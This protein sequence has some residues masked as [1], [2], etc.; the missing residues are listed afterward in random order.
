[1]VLATVIWAIRGVGINGAVFSGAAS[2]LGAFA[3]GVVPHSMEAVSAL[4]WERLLQSLLQTLQMAVCGTVLGI[5]VSLPLGIM[6]AQP[7]MAPSWLRLPV[8]L[9]LN[10]IRTLPSLIWALI[11]V[12]MVGLGP[13]SGVL[14]LSAYSMGYLT[15]FFYED[16]E[17]IDTRPAMAVRALGATRLQT[18]FLAILP[19][20]MPMLLGS[21]FF[22]FEYN[23][24]AASVLGV[25]GAGGIGQDLMYYIEWRQF[26]NHYGI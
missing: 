22:M 17:S 25:V 19:A 6:A 3:R 2:A 14:A 18:F 5:I 8:R 16:L 11:F 12:A 24:R 9:L 10:A 26:I 1:L 7:I 4:P 15:K 21:C 20:A 13:V 23:I